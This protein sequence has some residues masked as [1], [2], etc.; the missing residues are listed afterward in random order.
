MIAYTEH[1]DTASYSWDFKGGCYGDNNDIA[2]Y[3]KA[4]VGD[5]YDFNFVPIEVREDESLSN[6]IKNVGSSVSSGLSPLFYGISLIFLVLAFVAAGLF[7]FFFL[8]WKL[9]DKISFGGPSMKH[10]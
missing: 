8:K 9:G 7:L 5:E 10:Q 4:S 6:D 2:V 3:E 1:P